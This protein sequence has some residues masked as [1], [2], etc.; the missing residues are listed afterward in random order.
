MTW[1]FIQDGDH[2]RPLAYEAE[3]L[4]FGGTDLGVLGSIPGSTKKYVLTFSKI[5]GFVISDHHQSALVLIRPNPVILAMIWFHDGG[6][7]P[8]VAQYRLILFRTTTSTRKLVNL[9]FLATL[10]NFLETLKLNHISF[11]MYHAIHKHGVYML[12]LVEWKTECGTSKLTINILRR[13][14]SQLTWKLIIAWGIRYLIILF[15]VTK[16]FIWD[17]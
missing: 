7:C 17:F 3:S 2:A 10:R 9:K 11:Q 16:L 1:M 5:T 4:Q 14:T 12:F 8:A 6:V 15:E 13:P